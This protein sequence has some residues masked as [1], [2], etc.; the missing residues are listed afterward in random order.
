M[1]LSPTWKSIEKVLNT[2]GPNFFRVRHILF[3]D[4]KLS[5]NAINFLLAEP[6][7]LSFLTPWLESIIPCI[8]AKYNLD[9]FFVLAEFF[10]EVHFRWIVLRTTW[11]AL[12]SPGLIRGAC[13]RKLLSFSFNNLRRHWHK[14]KLEL[15]K[16]PPGCT[17][18]D[19]GRSFIHSSTFCSLM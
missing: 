16:R 17:Q 9:N 12:C 8:A 3:I 18:A 2:I 10:S 19:V 7:I 1:F 13:R 15:K 14:S 6:I 5:K 11:T 4:K